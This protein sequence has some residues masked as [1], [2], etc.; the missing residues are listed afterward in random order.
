LKLQTARDTEIVANSVA[1]FSFFKFLPC[2]E[3]LECCKCLKVSWLE[4]SITMILKIV[5]HWGTVREEN[6]LRILFS[7]KSVRGFTTRSTPS[8]PFDLSYFKR[9][10]FCACGFTAICPSTIVDK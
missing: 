9:E 4:A 10:F 2:F 8:I 5:T 3:A 1:G 6:A 7:W